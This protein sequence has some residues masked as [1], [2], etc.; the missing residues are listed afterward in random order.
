MKSMVN[1]VPAENQMIN[2]DVLS[3]LGDSKAP[4]KILILGNSI[5][6][7]GP[8]EPIGW[9]FDWGMAASAPEKDFVHRLYDMLRETLFEYSGDATAPCVQLEALLDEIEH[10]LPEQY[11]D[12]IAYS[13]SAQTAD[14]LLS[15]LD[16]HE[17][18]YTNSFYSKWILKNF[19]LQD[20]L[21]GSQPISRV[22]T[23]LLK[24]ISRIDGC[25]MDMV[26]ILLDSSAS[27]NLF[28]NALR[29]FMGALDDPKKSACLCECYVARSND[30][31]E[32]QSNRFEQLLIETPGAMPLAIQI[33]AKKITVAKKADEEFWRIYAQ[34]KMRIM[35]DSNI[36]LDPMIRICL[37]GLDP[38]SRSEV[39]VDMVHKL[40]L[41]LF[42]E[43]ETVRFVTDTINE[44]NLKFLSKVDVSILERVCELRRTVGATGLERIKAVIVGK[45]LD[46]GYA[47]GRRPANLSAEITEQDVS[48]TYFDKSDYEAYIKN[49]LPAFHSLINSSEDVATLMKFFFHKQF[50]AD[51]TGDYISAIKKMEKKEQD[52]WMRVVTW[53]C[54]YLLS[55][56]SADTAADTLYKPMI[57]YMRSLDDEELTLVRGAVSKDTPKGRC[58]QLFDEI[59]RKEGFSEKLS[60]FFHRK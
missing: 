1:T 38:S 44:C 20:M 17:N 23:A 10:E 29:L 47:Q 49:Y 59:K 55:S 35:S 9:H 3:F 5:T 34:H 53:T 21:S 42:R 31:S 46:I 12:F 15:Y 45:K 33:F 27:Q 58:D 2:S 14:Q 36:A 39:A 4:L 26:E 51:F 25:E 11:K 13:N 24:N 8:C 52:R 7:H 28:E 41:R 56:P 54:A 57:H 18:P 30:L 43:P 22:F 19:N 6:R 50:F 32:N 16:G 48:L 40:E 37:E 60:S